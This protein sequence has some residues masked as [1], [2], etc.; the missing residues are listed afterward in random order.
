MAAAE[1]VEAVLAGARREEREAVVRVVEYASFPR[2]APEPE[3]QL[4]FTR[5][6]SRS[7][8]CLGVDRCEGV[9][10]LLRLS[11]RDLEGRP[12]EAR[13]GRV[14][15]TSSERDGRHWLGVEVLTPALPQRAAPPAGQAVATDPLRLLRV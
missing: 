1:N 11:V 14:A 13:I 8:M 7:G 2:M 5:D 3:L 6:I 10:S 15:W 12:A 9:G 4:G